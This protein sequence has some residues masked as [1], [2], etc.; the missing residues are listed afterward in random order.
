[1]ELTNSQKRATEELFLRYQRQE[2]VV[3]FRAPTGAGKTFI[4]SNLI[5]KILRGQKNIQKT[6]VVLATLSS[7]Q[8]P[9]QF[10]TKVQYKYMPYLPWSYNIEYKAA[11]STKKSR[12]KD[13]Q[14]SLIAKDQ[15]MIIVG[16]ASFTKASI[17]VEQ[18]VF[19]QFLDQIR[20]ENYH[21]IYI[22]DE[23]HHGGRPSKSKINHFENQ[24]QDAA[25]FIVRMTAT[26][27]DFSNFVEITELEL[28]RDGMQLLKNYQERNYKLEEIHA[29]RMSNWELLEHVLKTFKNDIQKKYQGLE[30]VK[31]QETINPALLIQVNSKNIKENPN[32]DADIKRIIQEIRKH[33][34]NYVKYFGDEKT[35]N[36]R[37][38]IDL[39]EISRNNSAVDV[40]IFKVGPATGWDIPRACVLLQLRNISS[41]DLN[42]QTIGRIKRNPLNNLKLNPITD[43]YY[44][45]TN[46]QKFKMPEEYHYRL[47]QKHVNESWMQGKTPNFQYQKKLFTVEYQKKTQNLL[48][49]RK[50]DI[51]YQMNYI[52]S[53]NKPLIYKEDAY[54]TKYDLKYIHI[55]KHELKNQLELIRYIKWQQR[56]KADL[57]E[58]IR[59]VIDDLAQKWK[60]FSIWIYWWLLQR[61]WVSFKRDV[62]DIC[63]ENNLKFRQYELI[64]KAKLI[65]DYVLRQ[66]HQMPFFP[67]PKKRYL[68]DTIAKSGI[69]QQM[70][71]S[72]IEAIYMG[73]IEAIFN[74]ATNDQEAWIENVL[75]SKNPLTSEIYL[76]NVVKNK[77]Y[78]IYP[79]FIYKIHNYYVYVEVK[80]SEEKDIKLEK[81]NQIRK[82]FK[83]YTKK[84]IKMDKVVFSLVRIWNLYSDPQYEN[85]STI[86]E[87]KTSYSLGKVLAILNKLAFNDE[88]TS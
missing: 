15:T 13:Y 30:L 82:V 80:G 36:I 14:A 11:P 33:N 67:L 71:D 65:Q 56:K 29:A 20:N 66:E 9:E 26:P 10:A 28:A 68:Y 18:G 19:A 39:L 41:L 51:I 59:E 72:K 45:Y 69:K 23:A 5:A 42:I 46:H 75:W 54:Q 81:T 57:L 48:E 2:K 79:D 74:R 70:L 64:A 87:I 31:N 43:R 85:F 38:K 52:K 16:K 55:R 76:E 40:I 6:V 77:I 7:S 32:F 3:D 60:I 8:L 37:E 83:N 22:R 21:L 4:I 27:K 49:N 25:T 73:K 58:P 1:M 63:I 61:N 47:H 86:P 34:L 62:Y 84:A 12:A 88:T 24:I 78:K 17:F 53:E 44:Y 50:D 35:S